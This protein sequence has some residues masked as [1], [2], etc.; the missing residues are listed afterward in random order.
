MHISKGSQ[1]LRDEVSELQ[2]KKG[3]RFKVSE[4]GKCYKY[5]WMHCCIQVGFVAGQN[6]FVEKLTESCVNTIVAK[7][8][9]R[10]ADFIHLDFPKTLDK[11]PHESLQGKWSSPGRT[12]QYC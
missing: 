12:V 1:E 11:V 7:G 6:N 5:F 3:T 10:L 9:E 2:T 4:G 8:K